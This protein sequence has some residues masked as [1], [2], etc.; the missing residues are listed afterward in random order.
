MTAPATIPDD[1]PMLIPIPIQ[2]TP[3]VAIVDQLLPIA[4]ATTLQSMITTTKK[5]VGLI[6]LKP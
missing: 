1:I 2:A 4:S 5:Y 6:S 3:T